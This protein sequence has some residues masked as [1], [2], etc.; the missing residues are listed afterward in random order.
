L[1]GQAGAQ[2]GV[3]LGHRVIEH[4]MLVYRAAS[5]MRA[6]AGAMTPE[7]AQLEPVRLIQSGLRRSARV[8]GSWPGVIVRLAR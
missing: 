7:M 3:G 8:I 1:G 4:L 2:L 5:M 6:A